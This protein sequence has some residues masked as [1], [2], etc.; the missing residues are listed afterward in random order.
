[1]IRLTKNTAALFSNRR[2]IC[3]EFVAVAPVRFFFDVVVGF[4]KSILELFVFI[5]PIKIVLII[6]AP[7]MP[8]M[9]DKV[10]PGFSRP[11][12]AGIL[13]GL[14]VV[15][16]IVVLIADW[17]LKKS[18]E[19]YTEKF[20]VQHKKG[21]FADS[22]FLTSVYTGIVDARGGSLLLVALSGVIGLVYSEFLLFFALAVSLSVLGVIAL[23]S[24]SKRF[25]ESFLARPP[26]VLGKVSNL[27]FISCFCYLVYAFILSEQPPEFLQAIVAIILSRRLLAALSQKVGDLVWFRKKKA[28]IQKLFYRGH[29]ALPQGA[30]RSRAFID[31]VSRESLPAFVARVMDSLG[32]DSGRLRGC[33]WVES[34]LPWMSLVQ[35]SLASAGAEAPDETLV[36]K[37]YE[38]NKARTAKNELE[39]YPELESQGIIPT[40]IGMAELDGYQVHTFKLSNDWAFTR[41]QDAIV[42]LRRRLLPLNFDQALL[43]EYCSVHP[44]LMDRLNQSLLSRLDLMANS[45]ER[46]LLDTFI[47]ALP[48]ISEAVRALPLKLLPPDPVLKQLAVRDGEAVFLLGLGDWK[49]EPV[50]FS[51]WPS[52][53]PEEIAEHLLSSGAVTE[54]LDIE[55]VV[56]H[57]RLCT[58]FAELER[59]CRSGRLREGLK[60]VGRIIEMHEFQMG[61]GQGMAVTA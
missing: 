49:L 57:I 4:V 16:H 22:D 5:L 23:A 13:T 60:V 3:R 20:A 46:E 15:L 10:L 39:L 44:T 48:A 54:G 18:A 37:V 21:R 1:M 47:E 41:D 61:E 32:M 31:S 35:C 36:L 24:V 17:Y 8:V 12:W 55:A 28:A 58:L 40:F 2:K 30:G 56:S 53:S 43:E 14:I 26:A 29:A 50:G 59:H 25:A 7:E 33:G 45:D 42:G 6:A 52:D 11:E 38:L 27:V 9:F 19:S 34:P 51:L